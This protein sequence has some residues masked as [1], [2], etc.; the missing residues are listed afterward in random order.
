MLFP[1]AKFTAMNQDAAGSSLNRSPI[2]VLSPLQKCAIA[3]ANG[4]L[5][6]NLRN[7]LARSPK[8]AVADAD[9]SFVRSA[10]FDH[11]WII[12]MKRSKFSIRDEESIRSGLLD[13]DGAIA[14]ISANSK[15]ISIAAAGRCFYKLVPDTIAEAKCVEH[16]LPIGTAKDECFAIFGLP[17]IDHAV[18]I[19]P[20]VEMDIL[21]AANV[22][23]GVNPDTT[24]KRLASDVPYVMALILAGIDALKRI[25][26]LDIEDCW[27]LSAH[28]D[29]P[30]IWDRLLV[31]LLFRI[32]DGQAANRAVGIKREKWLAVLVSPT[33]IYKK[34]GSV[35]AQLRPSLSLIPLCEGTQLKEPRSVTPSGI[36]SVPRN[37]Y[38]PGGT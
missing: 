26:Q 10:N 34:R 24:A 15:E 12:A 27:I 18:R 30:R 3:E 1:L 25:E 14:I 31:G 4:T 20:R 35:F 13:K 16:I 38:I 37:R 29:G 21:D 2:S 9:N 23:D 6:I 33:C 17:L 36:V 11:G 7:L 22:I 28:G 8:S 5:T 19:P 32:V